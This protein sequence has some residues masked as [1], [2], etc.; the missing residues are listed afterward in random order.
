M[1]EYEKG[2]IQCNVWDKKV[3]VV[4]EQLGYW[5]HSVPARQ[6]SY[7]R[8]ERWSLQDETWSALVLTFSQFVFVLFSFSF[9]QLYVITPLHL[10][11]VN[12][13]LIAFDVSELSTWCF[14][15]KRKF[16]T[17]CPTELLQNFHTDLFDLA[18][19]VTCFS[20]SSCVNDHVIVASRYET[21]SIS[22]VAGLLSFPLSPSFISLQF[23][24]ASHPNLGGLR[25]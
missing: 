25:P 7:G 2:N 9:L 10:T 13:S 23:L 22:F 4:G 24:A 20:Y 3:A 17:G 1:L 5:G 6:R 8:K 12:L 21:A 16:C 11:Y 18:S 15:L 19:W 14:M